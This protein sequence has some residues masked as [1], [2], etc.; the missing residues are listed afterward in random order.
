[1]DGPVFPG[2]D[3]PLLEAEG[4]LTA[5]HLLGE[6]EHRRQ[7]LRRHLRLLHG[8]G[9]VCGL[10]VVPA[11]DVE[12]PWSVIVCPG[13]AIGPHGDEILVGSAVTTD[14][15]ESA[16]KA[17]TLHPAQAYVA[18]RYAET[19][20]A[21]TW[22]RPG[23]CGCG[24]GDTDPQPSR[25]RDGFAAEVLWEPPPPPTGEADLCHPG[26]RPCPGCYPSPHVVLACID[27]PD[28]EA[29]AITHE[30]IHLSECGSG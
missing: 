28:D 21:P 27:L 1:M 15:H 6:Q 26:R 16:W 30:R 22:P 3:R 11:G 7:R 25:I 12:H 8:W 24:C 2:P 4:P 5:G 13:Y 14:I 9:V 29:V 19:A 18:V 17:P 20:L 23:G 10:R